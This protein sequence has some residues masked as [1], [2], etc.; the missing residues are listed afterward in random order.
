[1]AVTLQL[2]QGQLPNPSYLG[3]ADTALWQAS[4]STN[5]GSSAVLTMIGDDPVGSGRDVYSLIRWD[6][7]AIP[8]GKQVV[9]AELV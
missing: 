8:P 5:Y 9:S 2:R 6:L 1:M 3:A 4:P 7:S